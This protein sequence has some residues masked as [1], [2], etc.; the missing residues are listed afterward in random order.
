MYS[1][2]GGSVVLNVQNQKVVF[3]VIS[4]QNILCLWKR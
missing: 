4:K 3:L 1:Q 2:K